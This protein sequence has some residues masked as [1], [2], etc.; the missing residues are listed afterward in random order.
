MALADRV[1]KAPLVGI[2]GRP[3]S[4][5]EL[6]VKLEREAPAELEALNRMM[7]ELGWSQERIYAEV[8]AEGHTVGKQTINRHRSRACRCFQ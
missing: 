4:M 6:V 2:H 8:T 7:F 3:C 1:D 5:G